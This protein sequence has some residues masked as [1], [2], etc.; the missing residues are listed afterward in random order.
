M[1]YE[2]ELYHHGVRGMHWGVRKQRETSGGR[3]Y[4]QA[5]ASV[6]THT[7]SRVSGPHHLNTKPSGVKIS[8]KPQMSEEKKQQYIKA[9]KIA[10]IGALAVVG[11][12]AL[13]K[14]NSVSINQNRLLRN[15]VKNQGLKPSRKV[16]KSYRNSY[17]RMAK[18]GRIDNLQGFFK[19][20]NWS[21]NN[22][23]RR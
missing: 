20:N 4:R 17:N 1:T 9:G 3:R 13:Y 12:V 14:A 2:S 15:A 5:R 18:A 10:A 8:Q 16:M 7:P 11:G 19:A 22:G 6:G 23:I 21:I